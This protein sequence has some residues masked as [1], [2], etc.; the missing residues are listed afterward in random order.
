V[1]ALLQP[2][3]N[4]TPHF[5]RSGW[6]AASALVCA[7]LIVAA[8]TA[9]PVAVQ[10]IPLATMAFALPS[11]PAAPAISFSPK[12][13]VPPRPRLVASRMPALALPAP[14]AL[15]AAPLLLVR[16][17]RVDVS[18]SYFVI[19]VLFIEPPPPVVLNGI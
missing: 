9:P 5:S 4:S 6:M 12:R 7:A 1:E 19:A 18:P 13:F 2:D 14:P 8:S 11:P 15:S 16:A 17:W 10:Q 3:R